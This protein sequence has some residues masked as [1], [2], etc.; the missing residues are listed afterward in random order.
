M[1][2][3]AAAAKGNH[4]HPAVTRKA[5]RAHLAETPRKRLE[6][7]LAVVRK[8]RSVLRFFQ[9]H[10]AL[11][12]GDDR[13]ISRAAVRHAG[14]RLAQAERAVAWL[15]HLIEARDD[16]RLEKLP[17][18]AAICAAFDS[19]CDEAVQ[20]AWCE[21]RLRPEARNG[22]YLGL[23]QMGSYARELYGHGP[24]AHDQAIAAH[25]YFVSSGRDWSPWSCKPYRAY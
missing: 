1:A 10:P 23:F 7:E 19:Y 21:S 4:H 12:T 6:R 25:K 13:N 18:K 24:T 11:L 2:H 14:E 3:A 20:V 16:R 22:Q 17:P 9:N 15:R 5:K 8:Q